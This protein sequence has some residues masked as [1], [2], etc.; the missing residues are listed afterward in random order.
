[1]G[2]A[3]LLV[4]AVEHGSLGILFEEKAQ[5]LAAGAWDREVER[6]LGLA[7]HA[8]KRVEVALRR[9]GDDLVVRVRDQ[10]PGFDPQRFLT[11]DE[12]RAFYPNGRGIALA[13]EVAV[14]RI[15]Y[16]GCGNEVEVR[17][18]AAPA[19]RRPAGDCA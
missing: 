5:L 3:E 12:S 2:L 8:D 14:A 13:R 1:M 16:L 11:L 9:D 6:R 10:G 15:E 18:P 4:N 19:Q 7:E 17:M